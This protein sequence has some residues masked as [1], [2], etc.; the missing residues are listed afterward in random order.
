[1]TRINVIPPAQLCDQHLLAEHRELPRIPNGV[2]SERLKNW[3]ADAPTKY[4][5]GAGH[6]KFFVNKLGWLYWR[7]EDITIECLRR[8]FNIE[9]KFPASAFD[10]VMDRIS[11]QYNPTPADLSLNLS[12]IKERWPAKARYYGKPVTFEELNQPKENNHATRKN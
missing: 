12:R 4:T 8:N 5:L 11:A 7:Y 9:Y 6:V 10:P 2:L 1:M 3:Y